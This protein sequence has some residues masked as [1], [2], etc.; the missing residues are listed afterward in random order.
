MPILF[1]KRIHYAWIVFA[2]T[3]IVLLSTAAIRS[4]PSI[5]I[6]P[7]QKEFGWSRADVSLGASINILLFGLVGPFAAG[8]MNYFGIRKVMMASLIITFTGVLLS[9]FMSTVLELIFTWGVLVGSGTGMAAVVLG[10][11]VVNRWFHTKRGVVL[12]ALTAANAT[13]QLLFLPAMAYATERH[14]WKFTSSII[15]VAMTIIF[16]LVFFLIKDHPAEKGLKP[17]GLE[18]N[19]IQNQN[20]KENP[21]RQ[22]ILSLWQGLKSFDFWLLA[23]SFF[24]CGASTNGLVGTHL[25]PACVDHG[26]PE[27]AAASLLAV[28]GIFDIIGTTCSGWLSDRFDNRKLL[29]IYYSLRGLSLVYLPY[30]FDH[31]HSGG[32]TLFAMFYGLDWIATVPPTVGLATQIFGREKAALMF[33]WIMAVHQI[34]ASSAAYFAGFLRTQEGNYT[35]AFWMA[36]FLCVITAFGVLLIG[37]QKRQRGNE[38]RT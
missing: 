38:V 32:L 25:V 33:A 5:F 15:L 27:V 30:G 17:Y 28:M 31:Y 11:T 23:G 3:F 26:I 19:P 6:V 8:L 34:G 7:L 4:T 2:V 1:K 36:G 21:F 35:H 18:E 20:S 12:G 9:L 22:T 24:V 16:P 13:G 10:A 14:S 37:R 29:F